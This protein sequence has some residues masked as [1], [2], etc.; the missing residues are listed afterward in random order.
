M[1]KYPPNY[2]PECRDYGPE[3]RRVFFA[4]P[5]NVCYTMVYADFGKQGNGLRFNEI[6]SMR[7]NEAEGRSLHSLLLF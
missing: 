5:I 2:G 7:Y 4:P 3:C 1:Q 6:I